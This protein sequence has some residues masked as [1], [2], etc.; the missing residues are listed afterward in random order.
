MDDGIITMKTM[1]T[2]ALDKL[3]SLEICAIQSNAS[4][5]LLRLRKSIVVNN[6]KLRFCYVCDNIL[7]V[8]QHN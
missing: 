4:T 6:L 1:L 2:F 8:F 3:C 5:T 7:H